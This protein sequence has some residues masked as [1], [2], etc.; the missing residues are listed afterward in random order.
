MAKIVSMMSRLSGEIRKNGISNTYYKIKEKRAKNL[1]LKDY[2]KERLTALPSAETLEMQRKTNFSKDIT[3]SIVVPT[4][5]TPELFLRQMTES[6]LGQTFCRVELCIADG[7]KDDSVEK[8]IREY[9]AS[10]P[11]VKYQ[12]LSEN[13]GI[14]E[15]SN[16]GLQMASGEY[17]GL[18]DHD[19]L[20]ELHALYEMRMVLE[21]FPDADVIY[22]DEDKVTFDLEHYFEPHYK[23][24]FNPDLLRS[25][26]YICH[27][28]VMKKTLL[29]SVGYFRPE[30]DGAQDF[31]LV[32][33]LTEKARR[34]VHI[35]KVLYHWRS[36]PAS[37][38]ANPMSKLYAY[39]SGR[40]AVEAHLQRCGEKGSVADTRFYGFY[41]T[42]YQIP[43]DFS[44]DFVF[45]SCNDQ[46]HKK[47]LN[48]FSG[49][50]HRQNA[51]NVIYYDNEF[52][53][54]VIIS[55]DQRFEEE[56]LVFAEAGLEAVSPEAVWQLAV[57]CLRTGIGMAG[58]RILS[59]RGELLY[60]RMEQTENGTL[61]YAD[62]G[63]PKGFTGYFHKAVLQQNTDG[64]SF[65]FFAVR[66]DLFVKWKPE[67]TD[68]SE[69]LMM[70][71]CRFV[72]ESGYRISYV[73]AATAKMKKG[74]SI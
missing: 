74:R 5:H 18:L 1:A 27:F 28:L 24:E 2:E 17:I 19:D 12:R 3:F 22:T 8:I 35:P 41:Q 54:F 52:N 43:R 20:L 49:E 36:H 34:V 50:F 69:A 65:R 38:A 44:V 51:G 6:V 10:D 7:S 15:N 59:D 32:L 68:S 4:Y 37:T 67:R 39:E 71:L 72:K 48:N 16:A 9:A 26:N 56:V 45:F 64:V 33:R 29:D 57:N 30:Y 23:P 66:K 70:Q 60:G 31:D 13:K 14:A 63:L 47:I 25:N 55:K 40:R 73:P 46:N 53:K 42:T 21:Q 62:A 58:G 61:A 11:R